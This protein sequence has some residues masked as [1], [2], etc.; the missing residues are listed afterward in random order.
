MERQHMKSGVFSLRRLRWK[1]ALS[2]TLVTVLA[3]LVAEMILVSA[4]IAFLI[5]PVIPSLAARYVGDEVAP[6]LESGLAQS[7]PDVEDLRE[8]IGPLTRD[9]NART[10]D[11]EG[12]GGLDFTLGKD[13]GYLLVV[14]DERRL[15]V[16]SRQVSGSPEGEHLDPERFPGLTPLLTAALRGE[17]DPWSL[18]AY[19]PG[20]EQMLVAAPVEDGG[21]RVLG[22]VLVVIR[23]PNL[24]GPLFAVIGVGALALTIPAALLGMIFGFLTAWGM[25]RR[26]QR[27]ARAAQAWSQG[28]F[29][30]AVKDRSRDEIGQLSRELNNMAAQLEA[31]IQARQE[32]ATLETRNRFARDLHDSV[33]QQVFAASFQI[34]AAR[35]MI[36]EDA[37][38]A[39]THLTQAE[40][41]A[42]QAQR[43]LNVLIQEMRPAAL[44][45]KGLA[46]A[47]RDYVEDWSRRTEVPAE[48]HVRGERE[49]PLE[50]E[51]ALF[52]VAQEA[53]A[54]VAKHSGAGNVEVDLIY[55]S[56]ALTLRVAD[57]G[58]GFDPAEK[59]RGEGFGLQSMHERLE[60]LGGR[61]EVESEPGKGTR[62]TC[63]CPLE[64]TSGAT[65]GKRT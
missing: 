28:D 26:L 1:L 64:S 48:V 16:S 61:V 38:A 4:L 25:T 5:S 31:L 47:L 41:L 43:E 18:G 6:R 15:L 36:E 55:A 59:N 20:R 52:R 2:Y 8:E 30:V 50:V 65:K 62:I 53:L 14:D 54:N 57:D 27:L 49:V 63:V 19:S 46:A 39:E 56:D 51:Q 29:S 42:R 13:D 11:G 9:T 40:E 60:S 21:G 22:A 17:E 7:P 32:L 33:K 12:M 3:L 45:G 23:L 58:R 35:A 34:A 10:A 24:T 44:E 37:K